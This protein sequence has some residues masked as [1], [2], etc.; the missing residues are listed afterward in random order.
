MVFWSDTCILQ[1]KFRNVDKLFESNS[2]FK[3]IKFPIKIRDIHKI[4][5]KKRIV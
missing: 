4:E 5:K 2:Y 1:I 3:D